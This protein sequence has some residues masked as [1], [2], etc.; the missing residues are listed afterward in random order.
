MN[1]DTNKFAVRETAFVLGCSPYVI[2]SMFKGRIEGGLT[3][4]QLEEV[5]RH[6]Q[7]KDIKPYKYKTAE[8]EKVKLYLN[9]RPEAQQVM[10]ERR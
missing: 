7:R 1:N 8:L 4:D 2:Y 10:I 9:E 6:L 5:I 3:E